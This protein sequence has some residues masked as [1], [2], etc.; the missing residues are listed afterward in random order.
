MIQ[1]FGSGFG[2]AASTWN[3]G[4]FAGFDGGREAKG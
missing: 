1:P 4:N 2:Q 3:F